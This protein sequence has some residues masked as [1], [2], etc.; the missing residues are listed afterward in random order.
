MAT[1][2]TR[3]GFDQATQAAKE[4]GGA[5]WNDAK[6]TARSA[7]ND[8]QRAAAS[9]LGDFAKVL[10]NAASQLEG[11]SQGAS[12][13]RLAQSAADGVERLSD[14]LRTRD[15]ESMARDAERFARNQPMVFFGA[16]MAVGFLAMRFMKASQRHETSTGPQGAMTYGSDATTYRPG[17]VGASGGH[18][19]SSTHYGS[20]TGKP[21]GTAG[22]SSTR[23]PSLGDGTGSD[24]P[25]NTRV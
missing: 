2:S 18:A 3:E 25:P 11:E 20:T 8:Q 4:Q 24:I 6:E 5:M 9:G 16:A 15:L 19:S 22:T 21:S 7:L 13:G 14:M 12:V 23:S 1:G 17:A 10:R